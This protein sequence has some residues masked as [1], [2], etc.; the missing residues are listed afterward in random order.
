[1]RLHHYKKTEDTKIYIIDLIN[2]NDKHET[3]LLFNT[4]KQL[5]CLHEN[6]KYHINKYFDKLIIIFS[7]DICLIEYELMILCYVIDDE[8]QPWNSEV[9]GHRLGASGDEVLKTPNSDNVD[10][11]SKT[12]NP[13]KRLSPKSNKIRKNSI[14]NFILST[15][16][17]SITIGLIIII[18]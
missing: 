12:S 15:V 18:L 10:N 11:I 17:I 16:S 5:R 14:K 8:S 9:D 3:D 1:M 13:N 4:I 2:I 6:W 7:S